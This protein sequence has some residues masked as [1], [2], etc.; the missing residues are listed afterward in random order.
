VQ[1][2]TLRFKPIVSQEFKITAKADGFA[3]KITIEKRKISL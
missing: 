1:S 2:F 3:D